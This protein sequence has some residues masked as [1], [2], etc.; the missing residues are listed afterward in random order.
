MGD[1]NEVVDVKQL[2][3]GF[4]GPGKG[5]EYKAPSHGPRGEP[6]DGEVAATKAFE[7]AYLDLQSKTI[8]YV[9]SVCAGATD[10]S[11]REEA[12]SKLKASVEEARKW[13]LGETYYHRVG[14][15][16][17]SCWRG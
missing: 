1:L 12:I 2:G 10:D 6:D 4:G 7:S 5:Y 17:G 8:S 14:L 3:P 16:E 9:R 11:R 15:L 13:W